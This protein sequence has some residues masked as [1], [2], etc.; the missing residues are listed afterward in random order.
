MSHI[1][2]AAIRPTDLSPTKMRRPIACGSGIAP[3]LI[4]PNQP[5]RRKYDG[6]DLRDVPCPGHGAR[7]DP[8][9]ADWSKC[10]DAS[11]V[12][13]F[14]RDELPVGIPRSHVARERPNVRDVSDFFR[15]AVNHVSVAVAG[16]GDELRHE[17]D[18][19]LSGT[20]AQLGADDIGLV[21]R[22]EPRFGLLALGF[23]ISDRR[24]EAVIDLAREQVLE[25]A[26]ITLRV[27]GHDH[28]VGRAGP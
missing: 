24:L 6:L 17:A 4:L 13:G 19:Y 21:D 11:L 27:G 12:S 14:G 5:S 15:A 9:H 28:L 7:P 2:A 10:R 25:S 20:G 16:H 3:M 18:G 8:G 1:A 22:N 26:P 23:A